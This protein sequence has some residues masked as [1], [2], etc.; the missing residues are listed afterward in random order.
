LTKYGEVKRI[1]EE[2]W[3]RIYRYPVYNGLRIV[4][5][6]LQKRIPPHLSILRN[7]ILISYE[8]QTLTYYGCNKPGHQYQEC[9]NKKIKANNRTVT[10]RNTWAHVV[11]NG[12][13]S[14]ETTEERQTGEDAMFNNSAEK[15]ERR[16]K[17]H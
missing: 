16:K 5:M 4:E 1:T 13:A 7:R 14:R 6:E 2:Q 8:G 11:T 12:A 17:F 10:K 15:T 9:P 3:S